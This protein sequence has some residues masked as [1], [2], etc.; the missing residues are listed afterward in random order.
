MMDKRRTD[1]AFM[2]VLFELVS[3]HLFS[4]RGIIVKI[5]QSDYYI[6][7]LQLYPDKIP[8]VAAFQIQNLLQ[9]LSVY[10]YQI[11]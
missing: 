6:K 7:T 2:K 3:K 9:Y 1:N 10:I 4:S 8:A 5:G 11:L